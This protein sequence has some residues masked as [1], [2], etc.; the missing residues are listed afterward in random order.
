M[1]VRRWKDDSNPYSLPRL[2]VRGKLLTVVGGDVPNSPYGAGLRPSAGMI[3]R[4]IAAS[5][6]LS[7]HVRLPLRAAF[8][9]ASGLFLSHPEANKNRAR[10]VNH[11]KFLFG[12][13]QV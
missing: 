9:A 2:S 8:Q 7:T 13:P 6:W 3:S 4:E 10:H 1:E 11:A 5:F 12:N